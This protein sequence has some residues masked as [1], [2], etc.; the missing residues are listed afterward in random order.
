ML[1]GDTIDYLKTFV[2][3]D[4]KLNLDDAFVKR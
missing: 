3:V 2:S 1:Y 4:L